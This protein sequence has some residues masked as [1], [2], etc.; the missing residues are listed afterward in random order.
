MGCLLL[1]EITKFLREPPPK[2]LPSETLPQ[3][4]GHHNPS[5]ER[6]YS[7]MSS[8]STDSDMVNVVSPAPPSHRVS[9]ENLPR[10]SLD[11][12]PKYLSVHSVDQPTHEPPPTSSRKVSVYLRVNSRHGRQPHPHGS[13]VNR[14]PNS[15]YIEASS[16]LYKTT[17]PMQHSPVKQNRRMSMSA[18]AFLNKQS[19]VP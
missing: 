11:D 16:D 15:N 4:H 2:F 6:K 12:T 10:N 9:S 17:T 14:R 18:V 3:T 13:P 5:F 7:N 19:T 1:L 8:L